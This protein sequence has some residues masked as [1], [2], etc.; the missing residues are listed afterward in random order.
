MNNLVDKVILLFISLSMY[1]H[2]VDDVYMIIPIL[3][4][5]FFSSIVSYKEDTKILIG[6]FVIFFLLCMYSPYFIYFLPLLCYDLFFYKIKYIF[7]IF[8][9]PLLVNWSSLGI[10]SSFLILSYVFISYVLKYRSISYENTKKNY[11]NVSDNAKELSLR[12]EQKN[13]ELLEKQDYEINLATL[14][15]RNRIARDIHDN[16]G[17]LLSRCLLQTGA[18][19]AINKNEIISDNLILIKDTLS[20][21]MDSIRNSVHNLHEDAI[22]L[23]VE[24]NDLINNFSFC[25]VKFDYDISN[26]PNKKIKYSFITITKEALSNII[27]HSNANEVSILLREHPALYQLIIKDNGSSINYDIEN[28]IGLKNIQDRVSSLGGSLN[29]STNNGFRIFISIYKNI[30]ERM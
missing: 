9:L 12:F 19:L 22:D 8:I 5:I 26:P 20:E 16:V 30:D 10:S 4:V 6:S 7:T 27:K 25:H 24:I 2:K 28:G 13:R 1:L 3:V 29:I 18:L 23:Q 17:H 21:A 14:T 11:Y 15:E